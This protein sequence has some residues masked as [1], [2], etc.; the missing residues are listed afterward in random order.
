MDLLVAEITVALF[1]MGRHLDFI[2][3]T[4]P[5]WVGT[6]ALLHTRSYASMHR[7]SVLL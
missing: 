2:A 6:A 3:S 7:I 4:L 1:A 5:T